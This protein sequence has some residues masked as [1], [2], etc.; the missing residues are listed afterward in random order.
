[1]ENKAIIQSTVL[2]Y[3]I[4]GMLPVYG[5]FDRGRVK[6]HPRILDQAEAL[7]GTLARAIGDDRSM[8]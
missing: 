1:M 7:G 5:I 6:R 8:P 4:A 3:R 2:G